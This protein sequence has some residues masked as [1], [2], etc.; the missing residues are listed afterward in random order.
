MDNKQNR[1]FYWEV[2]D[3]M[4]KNPN[5]NVN[6]TPK[7]TIKDV[8]KTILEQEKIYKQNNFDPKSNTVNTV[9]QTINVVSNIE[10]GYNPNSVA[11][12]KNQNI[13]G[14][15]LIKEATVADTIQSL[16]S[17][18]SKEVP[19]FGFTRP[20][21]EDSVMNTN[22]LNRNV[23]SSVQPT[24]NTTNAIAGTETTNT[25]TEPQQESDFVKNRR[26]FYTKRNDLQKKQAEEK[27]IQMG[28]VDTS[29]L[30][31]ANQR[32]FALNK[33]RAEREARG[34]S[35]LSQQDIDTRIQREVKTRE[36]Q[37]IREPKPQ[38]GSKTLSASQTSPQ[39]YRI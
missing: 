18:N 33:A 3:F 39:T 6:N 34:E 24:S 2:K 38:V 25:T 4:G 28:Q 9:S 12:T 29:K 1:Q 30:S 27:L 21:P 37:G 23:P 8:A 10:K 15:G 32:T 17:D 22:P 35:A 20:E 16:I 5:V 19:V 31:P 11:Y 7:S 26:V 14:F 36:L 13:N